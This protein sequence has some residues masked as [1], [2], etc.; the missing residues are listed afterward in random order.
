M[1]YAR[2]WGATHSLRG[3]TYTSTTP[4][5]KLFK[6][7]KV[8]TSEKAKGL[9]G[10]TPKGERATCRPT[11]T[12]QNQGQHRDGPKEPWASR[13]ADTE[14][15]GC[16]PRVAS[17]KLP[18]G[19]KGAASA[20]KTFSFRSTGC[21]DTT[22]PR[23]LLGMEGCSNGGSAR[24]PSLAAQLRPKPAPKLP[25]SFLGQNDSSTPKVPRCPFL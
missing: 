25:S 1:G 16:L 5:R 15:G 21:K 8:R 12:K 2:V 14:E 17:A 22:L 24:I 13:G 10:R 6:R 19:R 4:R 23:I 3:Q 9:G 18:R 20:R 11:K 7:K